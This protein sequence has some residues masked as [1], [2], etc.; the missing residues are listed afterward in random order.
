ML[1]FEQLYVLDRQLVNPKKIVWNLPALF[2]LKEN[3]DLAA[4]QRSLDKVINNHPAFQT[5]LIVGSNMDFAVK[6]DGSLF[7]KTEIIEVSDK[8]FKKIKN[9]L[10]INFKLFNSC[11]CKHVIYKTEHSSYLF[12]DVNHFIFDGTSFNIFL[13]EIYKCY[14]DDK[15]EIKKDYLYSVLE[16]EEKL[17]NSNQYIKAKKHYDR[18][19]IT[20]WQLSLKFDSD[21]ND[22]TTGYFECDI[23]E[24]CRDAINSKTTNFL[25]MNAIFVMIY[26]LA[27]AKYNMTNYS[28]VNWVCNGRNSAMMQN[29]IYSYFKMCPLLLDY[30]KYNTLS[31]LIKEVKHQIDSATAY[32][33]YPYVFIGMKNNI[34]KENTNFFLFQDNIYDTCDFDQLIDIKEAFLEKKNGSDADLKF[35]LMRIDDKYQIRV[36]YSKG[37]YQ[38]SLIK[39]FCN[40]FCEVAMKLLENEKDAD[41]SILKL[42]N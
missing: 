41:F 32:S 23:T 22:I 30:T 27:T 15:F 29:S 16:N 20:D 8:E 21:S 12:F 10:I 2:K 34:Q 13:N 40:L 25:G 24:L 9:D 6:Y 35:E 14:T 33:F 26:A 17:L 28:G 31:K 1:S 3:V 18:F 36:S 37:K 38:D 42:L 11:L 7:K 39:K 19:N 4:L 5:K